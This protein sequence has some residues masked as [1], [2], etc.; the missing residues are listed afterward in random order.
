M[1]LG[2]LEVVALRSICTKQFDKQ[3]LP[4]LQELRESLDSLKER[5]GRLETSTPES[6]TSELQELRAKLE[7]GSRLGGAAERLETS[8]K[9]KADVDS[10]PSVQQ[11]ET[12]LADVDRKLDDF[13]TKL[14]LK[15]SLSEVPPMS[16]IEELENEL[17]QKAGVRE[18]QKLQ[19]TVDRKANTSKVPTM[20]QLQEIQAQVEKK[21]D[22]NLC[23]TVSQVEELAAELKRKANTS[24]VVTSAKLDAVIEE[25]RSKADTSDVVSSAQLDSLVKHKIQ[26]QMAHKADVSDVP[27]LAQHKELAAVT[28]RKL[29]FLATKMQQRVNTQQQQWDYCQPVVFCA[30]QM[31]EGGWGG[32]ED[33]SRYWIGGSPGGQFEGGEVEANEAQGA[34]GGVQPQDQAA[35]DAA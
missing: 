23:P 13:S 19:A 34:H 5:V 22:S 2:A 28:E 26:E 24:S 16:S 21:V 1:P 6:V 10:V 7:E 4:A 27:S 25:L 9:S 32:E 11:F 12:L 14:Q 17:K 3:V 35:V 33:H 30:P 8:L 15:A 31:M 18:L 20:A 29:S